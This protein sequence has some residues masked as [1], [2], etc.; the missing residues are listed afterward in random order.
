MAQQ[1]PSLPP[2]RPRAPM[3][4]LLDDAEVRG[5]Q[6]PTTARE[7][8]AILTQMT[9]LE[10]GR[11]YG[12]DG[13]ETSF[14]RDATCTHTFDD[15]SLSRVHARVIR[16][17]AEYH[18]E[19]VASRNGVF[20]NDERVVQ[21]PLRDGDRVRLGSAVTLR[22]Q[23]V[24]KQEHQALVRVFESSVKDGLT[25][26]WNRRYLD[27]RLVG[28]LGFAKRHSAALAVVLVDIDHFKK[29]NDTHGHQVG[30]AVLKATAETMRSTIR[31]EDVLARYGGEEFLVIARGL[32]LA[33]G[34]QLGERLRIVAERHPVVIDGTSIPRTISAGVA[35]VDCCGEDRS[36]QCLL[37]VADERLYRAKAAGRNRVCGG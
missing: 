32:D 27:E 12:L 15:G 36:P 23:V 6:H 26:V 29:V 13:T 2:Q 35:T 4:T 7:V 14:G 10:A 37:R 1:P 5:P 25:G 16:L 19:D 24:T 31:V 28:E 33:R 9:G 20:V 30:D 8:H 11:V 17:G 34:V 18:I 3:A 22:F 21:T